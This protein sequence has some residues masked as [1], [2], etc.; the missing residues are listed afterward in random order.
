V[1]VGGIYLE[2]GVYGRRSSETWRLLEFLRYFVTYQILVEIDIFNR[3]MLGVKFPVGTKLCTCRPIHYTLS[4]KN[5]L[6]VLLLHGD[7]HNFHKGPRVFDTWLNSKSQE[8]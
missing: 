6:H 4:K 5:R 2:T 1:P 3:R 8:N 7:L